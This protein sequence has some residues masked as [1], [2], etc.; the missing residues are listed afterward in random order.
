MSHEMRTP[1]NAIIGMTA[2]A[3]KALDDERKNY[4]L[5]KV[6]ESSRHLL[7]LINDIL[8]MSKIEANKL[9][10]ANDEFDLNSILQRAVSF[11]RLRMDEKRHRFIMKVDENVP[12]CYIGDDLRLTQVITNLLTNAVKFTPEDGEIGINI[13][14]LG[15][16]NGICELCFEVT[17]SGIG[18][19]PEQQQ[20]IFNIFEQVDSSTTRKYGG[21][22][23]GL[24]ISKRIIEIMGGQINIESDLGKGSRFIFTVK[25]LR[26][27][28]DLRHHDESSAGDLS[29][30]IAGEF[31]GKKLLLAEDI[32][33]NREII[34]SLLDGSGLII[35]TAC[36]GKEAFGKIT[37]AAASYDLIFMDV[38]MPEMDGLEATR[39][40]RKFETESG[41]VQRIPIVAMTANVFKDDIENCLN[42]GMDDHIGKPLEPDRMIEKLKKYL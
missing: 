5:N 19:S 20:K 17:D 3:K 38:Q 39:L 37:A 10:L 21:T 4:A 25:L 16:E 29:L 12:S 7:G 9:E 32:E 34:V 24:T 26:D 23:L 42:A 15:E 11:V 41:S 35:D 2:I 31:T 1:M 14:L 13:L 33:I 40:I 18:I 27:E 22:G 30:R 28:N 6:E 8:D 36:N